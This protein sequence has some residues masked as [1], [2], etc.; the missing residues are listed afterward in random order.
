[1]VKHKNKF[2]KLQRCRD[3]ALR[4][5]ARHQVIG[6]GVI[7]ARLL[8]IGEGPGKTED[9]LAEA[10]TG[11]SGRLLNTMIAESAAE[12]GTPVPTYYITNTVLCRP[13]VWEDGDPEQGKNREPRREEILACMKNVLYIASIVNPD[14]V[15]FVG[16]IA[17]QVYKKEFK[18]GLLI[19]HPAAHLHF[20]GRCSPTYLLDIR[21]LSE[22]FKRIYK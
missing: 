5:H 3:C 9:L 20:G 6:R 8:F 22:L 4:A 10:F 1:M 16:R 19:T 17:A 15:I 2:I 11:A 12:A 13:W 21:N 18:D 7:P 14:Y